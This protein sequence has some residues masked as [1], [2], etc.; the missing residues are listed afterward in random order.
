MWALPSVR[1]SK[2]RKISR[3]RVIKVEGTFFM[4]RSLILLTLCAASAIAA[5][6]LP[7]ENGNTWTYRVAST[8]ETLTIR[9]GT[10]F[11]IDDRVYYSLSGFAD[12]RVLA[13][14]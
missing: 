1:S 7:L 13:R 2:D 6:F 14:N 4:L 10:P 12:Q 3:F 5:D 8:G 9:V 11:L